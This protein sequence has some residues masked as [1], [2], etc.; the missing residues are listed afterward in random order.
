MAEEANCI[1]MQLRPKLQELRDER[2]YSEHEVK[3]ILFGFARD[4][5]CKWGDEQLRDF[6][7]TVFEFE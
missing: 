4:L 5:G 6:I 3:N 7:E 1:I 2:T